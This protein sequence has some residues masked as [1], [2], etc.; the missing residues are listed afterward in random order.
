MQV[1]KLSGEMSKLPNLMEKA[2]SATKSLNG[3]LNMRA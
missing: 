3:N 1:G 2:V